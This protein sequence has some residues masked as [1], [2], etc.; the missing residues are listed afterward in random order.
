MTANFDFYFDFSSPYGYLASTQIEALA[1]EFERQ[2]NWHPILLGPMF[3][4]M[5]SAPLSEIPL[6]GKYALHDFE[7]SARLFGIPY[8]Q[9]KEFPI[10]T[11]AAARA[12]LYLQRNTPE[13]AADFAKRIYR[14]Y[15]AE[16]RDIG[17]PDTVLA[18][19]EEAGLDRSELANG[20]ALEEV[21]DQLKKSVADAMALG[22]FGSPFIVV[23]GEPFWGF[24]R[25]DHIRKWLR[26]RG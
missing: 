5:G 3:K 12:V 17:Q 20:M 1:A 10:G 8:A 14:G 24:D 6:K 15:F 22:I 7:R 23:D 18:L 11:V 13:K 19:A 4:A 16:G 2:V 25:F 9:P 21:K 26:T